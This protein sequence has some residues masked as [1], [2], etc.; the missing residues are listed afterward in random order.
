VVLPRERER[1]LR[2]LK[3]RLGKR[4]NNSLRGLYLVPA[5]NGRS[6]PLLSRAMASA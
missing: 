2:L 6:T 3:L 5:S 4:L 1:A